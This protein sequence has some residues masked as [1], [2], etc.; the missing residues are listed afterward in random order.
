MKDN[1]IKK[2]E[3]AFEK[4][5]VYRSN[6]GPEETMDSYQM[7][8]KQTCSDKREYEK[9]VMTND[10][11]A[12]IEQKKIMKELEKQNRLDDDDIENKLAHQEECR[13]KDDKQKK[14]QA[15]IEKNT[16]AWNEQKKLITQK[17]ELEEKL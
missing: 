10:L 16:R 7:V 4:R 2:E 11:T 9:A 13:I 17:K 14:K 12:Q 8:E 3:E 5:K 15:D 1:Q 6:Y